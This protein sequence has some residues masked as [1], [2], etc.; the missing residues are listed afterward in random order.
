MSGLG[1]STPIGG[2]GAVALDDDSL[3]AH[4]C[5]LEPRR[6]LAMANL[7]NFHGACVCWFLVGALTRWQRMHLTNSSSCTQMLL[8]GSRFW[9]M[10]DQNQALKR[11]IE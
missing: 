5:P 1:S 10:Q 11:E 9:I 4:Q 6:S 3:S 2:V 7:C 8:F